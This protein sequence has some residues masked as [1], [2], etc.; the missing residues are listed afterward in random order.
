MNIFSGNPLDIPIF[1]AHGTKLRTLPS[2]VEHGD[3]FMALAGSIG[4]RSTRA[5]LTTTTTPFK[6]RLYEQMP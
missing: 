6:R 5:C 3:H 2:M 4:P 1:L